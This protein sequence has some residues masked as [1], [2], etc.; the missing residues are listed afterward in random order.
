MTYA[1]RF[2]VALAALTTC[3]VATVAHADEFQPTD[4]PNVPDAIVVT[5]DPQSGEVFASGNGTIFTSLELKS[6]NGL[7]RPDMVNEGVASGPF[8]VNNTSKFFKLAT[9]GLA[10][11]SIGTIAPAGMSMAQF[12]DEMKVDGSILPSGR[13]PNAAGGGPFLYVVPEPSSLILVFCGLLG[14]LGLRRK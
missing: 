8:D 13:L 9:E 12:M 11:L 7:L 10:E 6:A 5:Y 2:A 14:L 3:S 1:R 4:N